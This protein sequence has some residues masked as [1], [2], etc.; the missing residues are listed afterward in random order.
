MEIFFRNFAALNH[1]RHYM[2]KQFTYIIA[3]LFIFISEATAHEQEFYDRLVSKGYAIINIENEGLMQFLDDRSYDKPELV[4][5]YSFSIVKKYSKGVPSKPAGIMLRWESGTATENISSV[6]VTLVESE[7]ESDESILD[8]N[9]TS[10]KAK[11]YFPNISSKEYFLC[12]MCPQRYCYYKIE[13][14][15]KDGHRNVVK[16]GRFY[17]DGQI[18]MLR[19]DGM[20]NVRDFGGWNTLL[21][22]PVAY[23]RLFRGGRAESITAT[24]KND[25][26]KNEH[27][28]ADLDLRG[29]N[30]GKSPMG[31]VD[32]VE[33][34]CTN[35]Q[36][37]KLALTSRT[38]IFVKDLDFIAKVLSKGG[39]VYMHCDHGMN[40]CGTLS[41]LIEGILG[42][43]EAD[44]TRDYEL[45]S[46]AYGMARS[47]TFGAMLPVI[48]S[49][50]KTGDDLAQCFYNFARSIGVSEST[51]D[52]IRCI[53]LGMQPDDPIIK[54]AHRR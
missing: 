7:V 42:Y 11:L 13:E 3:L 2:K 45:S 9:D 33:Y 31:P 35:N 24:G 8:S 43:T 52:T 19:V 21:G 54:N 37:Y 29:K 39:S 30:L 4:S 41:F 26:V 16:K 18:R 28:S 47:T 23:G 51:L 38:D 1:T 36:R 53:M 27:I 15:L 25:F 34:F 14:V 46:F 12:N 5:N 50:G 44:L 10:K 17:T 22:K 48:R 6:V 20:V 40:R 32:E 49:Y